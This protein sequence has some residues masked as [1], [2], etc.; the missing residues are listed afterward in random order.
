MS[1]QEVYIAVFND[2]TSDQI[3]EAIGLFRFHSGVS[4][5]RDET[6]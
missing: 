6:P 1:G 3:S 2:A 5:K 4:L